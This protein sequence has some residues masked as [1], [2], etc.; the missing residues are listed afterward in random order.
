MPPVLPTAIT[1]ACLVL[2]VATLIPLIANKR[3]DTPVLLGLAVIELA[4]LVLLVIGV[5]NL[6]GTDRDV[7]GGTFVGYLIATALVPLIVAFLGLTEKSRWGN[8]VVMIGCLTVPVL[9][10]RLDQLW[11]GHA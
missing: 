8:V 7:Y 11:A 5:V 6:I 1:I 9:I 4:L 10:V 2:A 3:V